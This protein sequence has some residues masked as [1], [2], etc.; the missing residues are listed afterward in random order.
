MLPRS[1]VIS[2]GTV[3]KTSTK[4]IATGGFAE[5][6][7]GELVDKNARQREVCLKRIGVGARDGEREREDNEEV[8]VPFPLPNS[9]PRNICGR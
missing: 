5:I 7:K 8:R 3:L 1:H 2:R 9:S 6:W 4:E